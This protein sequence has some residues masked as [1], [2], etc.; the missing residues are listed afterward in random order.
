M[1]RQC[2]WCVTCLTCYVM[3]MQNPPAH[4]HSLYVHMLVNLPARQWLHGQLA[5]CTT[6]VTVNVG[7]VTSCSLGVMLTLWWYAKLCVPPSPFSVP[8]IPSGCTCCSIKLC[9][10]YVHS[11]AKWSMICEHFCQKHSFTWHS[12]FRNINVL[13]WFIFSFLK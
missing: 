8:T 9:W 1:A 11:P 7:V 5:D 10:E 2:W 13:Y 6:R 3:L 4:M 12:T